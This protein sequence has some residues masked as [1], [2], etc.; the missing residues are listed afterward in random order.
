[1]N[2]KKLSLVTVLS[3]MCLI[4]STSFQSSNASMGA[5]QNL[6]RPECHNG[7]VMFGHRNFEGRVVYI[8]RSYGN[9]STIGFNDNAGSVC[10]PS[11]W[12]IELF[13]HENYNRT[14]TPTHTLY[15]ADSMSFFEGSGLNNRISSVRVYY[16]GELR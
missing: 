4:G 3:G 13:N 6:P 1:M 14:G 5:K 9:L 12:V 8:S 7:P 11:G 16:N 15:G 2:I 10:L